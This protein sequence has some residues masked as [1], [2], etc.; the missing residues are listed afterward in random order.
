MRIRNNFKVEL[1]LI[2]GITVV[3]TAKYGEQL[4]SSIK[5]Y[6]KDEFEGVKTFRCSHNEL[7]EIEKM[8]YGVYGAWNES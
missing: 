8:G 4:L 3:G 1:D 5:D 2:N 7:V 6:L